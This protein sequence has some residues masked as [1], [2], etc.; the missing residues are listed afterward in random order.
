MRPL[1]LLRLVTALAVPRSINPVH[2]SPFYRYSAGTWMAAT[3]CASMPEP[4]AAPPGV[5]PG[6]EASEQLQTET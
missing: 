4:G 2:C 6:D 5:P 1:P 3:T